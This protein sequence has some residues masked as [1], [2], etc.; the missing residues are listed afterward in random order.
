MPSPLF[1]QQHSWQSYRNLPLVDLPEAT[2]T[3]RLASPNHS[4][5]ST[6]SKR[7]SLTTKRWKEKTHPKME[8]AETSRCPS[9]GIM[10]FSVPCYL[11]LICRSRPSPKQWLPNI[12]GWGVAPH[13]QHL[14]LVGPFQI[15]NQHLRTEIRLNW[16]VISS[17]WK[18]L[19]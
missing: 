7:P 3:S 13:F 11:W 18:S 15:I 17:L 1:L 6:I 12:L 10:I 16:A 2:L 14:F 4:F 19:L 8:S 5:W 9:K